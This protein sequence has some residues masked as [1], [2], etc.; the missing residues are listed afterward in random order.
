MDG[1]DNGR[2]RWIREVSKVS[3]CPHGLPMAFISSLTPPVV[4]R[5][6]PLK[7]DAGGIGS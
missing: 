7:S 4:V 1:M 2:Q 6:Q 3:Q 5:V